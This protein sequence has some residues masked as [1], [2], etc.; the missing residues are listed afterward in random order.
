MKNNEK[1]YDDII[2]E[3]IIWLLFMFAM[4]VVAVVFKNNFL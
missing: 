4:L 3:V 2:V 1:E